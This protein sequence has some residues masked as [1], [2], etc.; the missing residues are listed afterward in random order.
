MAAAIF[1]NREHL[2]GNP[3]EV[4][5]AMSVSIL[6]ERDSQARP[7]D[8]GVGDTEYENGQATRVHAPVVIGAIHLLH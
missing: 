6:S 7:L 8:Q 2:H 5:A 1:C 3:R 4:L